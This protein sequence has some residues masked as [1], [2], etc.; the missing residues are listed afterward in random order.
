M[1]RGLNLALSAFAA[2]FQPASHHLN[3]G[4]R[5]LSDRGDRHAFALHIDRA[6]T[7]PTEHHP[8]CVAARPPA[9]PACPRGARARSPSTSRTVGWRTG[10]MSRRRRC[11]IAKK[12]YISRVI[13]WAGSESNTR[14]E[15]FQSS[16]LPT[17]L[18]AHRDCKRR[19]LAAVLIRTCPDSPL[20]QRQATCRKRDT[21]E[22]S[23][24]RRRASA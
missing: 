5:L 7:Q 12:L 10:G 2:R 18:P 1:R 17:E 21:S 11:S 20:Q 16:A 15:D 22:D 6:L 4:A 24:R 9:S 13:W 8:A 14:H 23:S 19:P 3:I